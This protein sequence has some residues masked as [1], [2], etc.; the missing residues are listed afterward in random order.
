MDVRTSLMAASRRLRLGIDVL[1][2][3]ILHDDARLVQN[4]VAEADAVGERDALVHGPVQRGVGIGRGER[5]GSPEAII[6]A[7]TMAVVWSAS[8]SSSAYTR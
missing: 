4:H 2:D 1:G 8:I 5:L 6:S 7:S 3:E